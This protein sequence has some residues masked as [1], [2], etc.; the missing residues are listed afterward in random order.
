MR[1][2]HPVNFQRCQC[3]LLTLR[4]SLRYDAT[5]PCALHAPKF[6]ADTKYVNP[7]DPQD[8]IFQ[9]AKG[10][11]RGLFDYYDSEPRESETFDHIMGGVMMNQASWLNIFPHERLVQNLDESSAVLVDV[12]GNVGRD[13]DRFRSAHPELA[14]RL[15]LQDR[16]DVVKSTVCPAPVQVMG[17]DFF[18]PQSVQ[19]RCL[20]SSGV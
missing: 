3:R 5:L 15:V 20:V 10:T 17:A 19:G 16:P 9:F 8:G 12:G 6:L 11:R 14:A 18:Q 1:T 2:S 4:S 7:R 13:L